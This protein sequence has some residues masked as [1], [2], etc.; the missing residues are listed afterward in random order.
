M[1]RRAERFVPYRLLAPALAVE[2]V[3]VLGPLLVGLWYSLHNVRFFQLRRFVGLE[4]YWRV[5][6]SEEVI[7]A[8]WVTVVFAFFALILTFVL[9]YALATWLERDGRFSTVMR[10]VVLVPY[11]IAM[12][13]GSM[14]LKWLFSQEG[15]IAPLALGPFGLGQVSVLADPQ[16]AM[17]ALVFNAMWRDGAFAM[18]MLLAGLKAIPPELHL[19]ARVDGA[20]AWMRFRRIT[21]PL[22]RIP[23]LITLVRL[24]V[25]FVN[26]LTFPLILT[27]GGPS[28]ATE[29]VVLKVFRLG[30]ADH[31]LGQANAL[32]L[33]VFV[34][35]LIL[36]AILLALFRRAGRI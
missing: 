1:T 25:H 31:V 36:V 33:L 34:A 24:L 10:A 21:I 19:A 28:N 9:G 22:M 16:L 7:N 17:G 14:L 12:L 3:L 8:L 13:V 6:G 11:M 29:V 4:N 35:N 2:I 23:I 32:A 20:S 26:I 30:F 15:G 27:G 5:L 18:I